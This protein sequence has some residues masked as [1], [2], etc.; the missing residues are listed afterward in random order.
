MKPVILE[1]DQDKQTELFHKV[2]MF[3]IILAALIVHSLFKRY[4]SIITKQ[5]FRIWKW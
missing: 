5:S 2:K 3:S 1:T 4:N